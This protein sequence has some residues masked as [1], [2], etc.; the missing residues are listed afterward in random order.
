MTG[1]AKDI[2]H[3]AFRAALEAVEPERVTRRALHGLQRNGRFDVA[4]ISHIVAIGKAAPA[5]ARGARAEL[6]DLPAIVVS[7]HPGDGAMP[8][9]EGDHPVP[10][11]RSFAAGGAVV[12]F[13]ATA[14]GACLF[15]ISGGGSALCEVAVDGVTLADIRVM[16]EVLLAS[17][18]DIVDVNAFRTV[19]SDLKAGGM[20]RS[21][22]GPCLSLIISDVPAGGPEHVASGPTIPSRSGARAAPL[23]EAHGLG[24]ALPASV[25]EAAARWVPNPP[26]PHDVV[27]V[28]ASGAVAADAAASYLQSLGRS[29]S[30]GSVLSGS[31]DDEVLAMLEVSPGHVVVRAGEAIISVEGDGLG[32]RN[33]HAALIAAL[34]LEGSPGVFAA[35]GTDGRD[36]DTE[37]AGAVVDGT[38]VERIM[39]AGL[40]AVSLAAAFDSHRALGASGDLVVT[41]ATGTN[42]ADLWLS[43]G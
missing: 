38:T 18:L 20:S 36:G 28:V 16:N 37:A 9:I 17:G 30:I 3:G 7:S 6:G 31:L 33:Q 5:M 24:A 14:E 13:L 22:S 11:P 42:V 2:A 21:L 29:V 8:V 35:F 25:V 34:R 32:G 12:D 41:G 10:G 23:V 26:R 1:L 4:A 40:D 39:Q 27:E 43:F 15:L 19:V